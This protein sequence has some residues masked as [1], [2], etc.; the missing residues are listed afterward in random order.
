MV[1]ASLSREPSRSRPI[2]NPR[3]D[4]G[5]CAS[6]LGVTSTPW[7]PCWHS[8]RDHGARRGPS[9][10]RRTFLARLD[11]QPP[12]SA[13]C[14]SGR[15]RRAKVYRI[16]VHRDRDV[17][18]ETSWHLINGAARARLRRRGSGS[19]RRTRMSCSKLRFAESDG[20]SG[21]PLPAAELVQLRVD[22]HRDG[23]EPVIA[24]VKQASATIPVVIG[25]ARHFP[26]GREVSIAS[27]ARPGRQHYRAGQ[28]SPL[29]RSSGRAWRCLKEAVPRA[30]RVAFFG[31]L[32]LRVP[33]LQEA[34]SQSAARTLG[35][36][37]QPV[38]RPEP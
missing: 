16:G 8:F 28:R 13:P 26:T 21:S 36:A 34:R 2:R 18:D 11:R 3:R 4:R 9:V 38:E 30:S 6:C 15:S 31:I 25:V 17:A 10:D 1:P 20:K 7:P 35:V 29:P 37:L 27:L 23:I 22:L 12:R 32:Y 5:P 14:R 19:R 24:A 33:S